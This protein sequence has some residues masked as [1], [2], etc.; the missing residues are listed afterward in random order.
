MQCCT[1]SKPMNRS[2]ACFLFS[3]A[4]LIHRDLFQLFQAILD[5]LT[6]PATPA[7][8][9]VTFT[10]SADSRISCWDAQTGAFQYSLLGHPHYAMV[11]L[12]ASSSSS[13]FA[14]LSH[15]CVCDIYRDWRCNRTSKALCLACSPGET[16]CP[17]WVCSV[18]GTSLLC[19]RRCALSFRCSADIYLF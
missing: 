9:A 18:C 10:A 6:T 3:R 11:C 17:R 16:T 14:F 12:L 5:M 2:D 1:H 13:P 15:F 4:A 7:S 8:S 19:P